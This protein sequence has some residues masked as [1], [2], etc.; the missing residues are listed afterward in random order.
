MSGVGRGLFADGVNFLCLLLLVTSDDSGG[1]A[2]GG[3]RNEL[4]TLSAEASSRASSLG[5]LPEEV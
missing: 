4:R 5:G 1:H 2:T 3:M